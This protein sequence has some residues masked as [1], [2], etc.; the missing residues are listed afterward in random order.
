MKYGN[1]T[2]G[3]CS[4]GFR[5][6]PLEKQLQIVSRDGFDLLELGIHGHENDY[7]QLSPSNEQIE[8]VKFL[9]NKYGVK[10]LCASTGNDFTESSE[11]AVLESVK[12]VKIV[13]MEA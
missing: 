3:Y 9:F 10:L 2:L 8:K 7:L 13:V 12:N 5:E 11:F 4:W 1:L 6:T